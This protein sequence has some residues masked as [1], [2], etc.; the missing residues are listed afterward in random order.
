VDNTA[1]GWQLLQLP[2]VLL[3]DLDKPL[4]QGLGYEALGKAMNLSDI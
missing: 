4:I 1:E 2:K 3:G